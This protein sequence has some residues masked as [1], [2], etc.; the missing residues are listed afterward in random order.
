MATA[1]DGPVLR[2]DTTTRRGPTT[3]S[4]DF[5]RRA[6]LRMA[7]DLAIPRVERLRLA[8]RLVPEGDGDWLLEARLTGRAVQECVVTFVP[9]PALIDEEIT[10]RYL[11]QVTPPPPGESEV[12]EEDIE[13]APRTLDLR[14]IAL[15]ELTLALPPWPRAPGI[16]EDE[17]EAL[18]EGAEPEA[19]RRPFA[20]LAALRD[21]LPEAG[22]TP[23]KPRKKKD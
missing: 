5:D 7:K 2:F 1:A 22:D 8:G 9:V 20:G 23:P 19:P 3:F 16:E 11:A 21:K 15:E 13:E 18:P 4:L 10:R 17:W 6:R 12:P 14:E